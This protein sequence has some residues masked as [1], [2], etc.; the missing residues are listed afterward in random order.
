MTEVFE[1][2]IMGL[3]GH[4]SVY[5][6]SQKKVLIL[7][8]VKG[9]GGH[10]QSITQFDTSTMA[11]A[12]EWSKFELDLPCPLAYFGCILY[13]ERVLV[14]FG[15]EKSGGTETDDIWCLDLHHLSKGWVHASDGCPVSGRFHAVITSKSGEVHLFKMGTNQHWR[16]QMDDLLPVMM[17]PEG[18]KGMVQPMGSG[19]LAS[20]SNDPQSAAKIKDLEQKLLNLS[21]LYS[22]LQEDHRALMA[23]YERQGKELKAYRDKY[24]FDEQNYS[25][26]NS[27]MI[28]DWIMSLEWPR[29]TSYE[30][31]LRK[32]LMKE[33][34]DG[35]VLGSLN[36]TD[37]TRFGIV[38]IKDKICLEKHLR[39]LIPDQ[40]GD[41]PAAAIAAQMNDDN[42]E[43]NQQE[44]ANTG[45]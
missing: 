1:F 41:A 9:W 29:F 24:G 36:R 31:E 44:G 14:L 11:Q 8:G 2:N 4:Q 21:H 20:S 30:M 25:I 34:V 12:V 42:D 37:W 40:N 33:G 26:W 22:A 15:G 27:D 17:K 38:D 16:I 23:N 32:N 28:V 35:E 18:H 43:L 3:F 5:I 7:G 19:A 6:R 10:S 45:L 39:K 13:N